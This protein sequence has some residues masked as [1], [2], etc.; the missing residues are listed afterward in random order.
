MTA[1]LARW[2][3]AWRSEL[4]I[5]ATVTVARAI[6]GNLVA[7]G[8]AELI[9]VAAGVAIVASPRARARADHV[10][11]DARHR[12]RW[13][14][15][16]AGVWP[17]PATPK[18]LSFGQE[19]YGPWVQ[20]RVA[21]G[22]TVDDLGRRA[23][24][25]GAWMAVQ[26]VRVNADPANAALAVIQAL[27]VDPLAAAAARWPWADAASTNI[28]EPVP[29]GTD[30]AGRP[31]TIALAG[32][33]LL[34]GGEPGSGKSVALSQ[35]VAAAALD[36]DAAM[37]L[38]DGKLVELAA[39]KGA[40][41]G[42]AGTDIAQATELLRHVQGVMEARYQWLLDTARRK[43]D[44]GTSLA[45]VVIDEL[46]HYLTWA[47][48]KPRDGFSDV[49]RDLVSRGR[50]AGVV[51]IAATQKPST[52]IIPSSLRDLFGYRWALRC[53]TAAASDTILGSGAAT[54]GY[55]ASTIAP[56]LRGGGYLL[57]ESGVPV[58][59]RAHHLSDDDIARLGGL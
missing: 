27:C 38:L 1:R 39:W 54:N 35:L 11:V 43:I 47:D 23:G 15:A 16:I 45:I 20:V 18:L 59:C 52:D 32:H 44:P 7:A 6:L 10:L 24:H 4:A 14:A 33:N 50:A 53:T 31:V 17:A 57:H 13:E 3:R 22:S 8:V 42:F 36:P 25:L 30:E 28:W 12:R 55:S 41:D 21:P 51:V 40:A 46:A 48:K 37:F 29:V 58:R 9:A 5:A 34:I 19:R 49:L 56:S 26:T 2:A